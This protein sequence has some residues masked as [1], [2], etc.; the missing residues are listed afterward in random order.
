MAQGGGV[1]SSD[2]SFSD[3]LDSEGIRQ[4]EP[5]P[6]LSKLGTAALGYVE[7]FGWHV[8]PLAPMSKKPLKGSAGFLEASSDPDQIRRWW[9]A[10]P[11][12]NI[13]LA[14]KASGLVVL[15]ADL[16]KD[17]CEFRELEARLGPLPETP[18]QL[19][20]AGGEHYIFRDGVG[21]GYHDPCA[22]AETKH[23]GYVLLHPS[24]HPNG[25]EY[26]PDL[27]APLGDTP[28]APLPDAWL[29]HLTS[30]PPRAALPSSGIDAADSELGRKFDAAGMLGD[31]MPEGRRMVRCPWADTHTDKRGDGKDSSAVLFPRATGSSLGGF[32]C[33]H[34]HCSAR[35][36]RDVL[37]YFRAH[38]AEPAQPPPEPTPEPAPADP[39]DPLAGCPLIK[40]HALVGAVRVR[41]MAAKPVPY[42]WEGIA[43]AA[44]I[45]AF[46][47]KPGGGKTTLLFLVVV[48]RANTG[49]PVYLL[50]YEMKPAPAG[51]WVVLI[52]AEQSDG[53]SA[54]KL[55]KSVEALGIGDAALER[56]VTLARKDVREGSGLYEEVKSLVRRGVVSDIGID[57]LSKLSK[58]AANAEE[59]QAEVFDKVQRDLIEA[60]PGGEED[61]PIVWLVS[62]AT[63]AGDGTSV[64]DMSGSAQRAAQVD[65][66]INVIPT[67]DEQG[68]TV[69]S[70]CYFTKLREEPDTFPPSVEFTVAKDAGGTWRVSGG[71]VSE[72]DSAPT[73]PEGLLD[74]AEPLDPRLDRNPIALTDPRQ[75][76]PNGATPTGI[77][78]SAR[79]DFA[80]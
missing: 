21:T 56:I 48:A 68:R 7:R 41:E 32:H 44:Q 75:N 70:T 20:P 54:R 76:K 30:P 79:I 35:G 40:K 38:T 80:A 26:T 50:G 33:S 49:A 37:A 39:S 52:E 64:D 22:G 10:A 1:V 34:S 31:V 14:C 72:A 18:R 43:T 19:T 36:W 47:G 2:E 60:A 58:G 13:G 51:K 17:T 61:K 73:L 5:A 78:C 3:W 15:D 63:K 57:S 24:V 16:Y 6:A 71:A 11:H 66:L 42:V 62:H 45:V 25:L 8:F 77:E 29:A 28:I 23:D 53:S 69:S 65:T 12:A 27:G 67:K 9:T 59:D 46:N 74:A 4:P 55:V